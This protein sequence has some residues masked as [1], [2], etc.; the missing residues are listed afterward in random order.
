MA[1]LV[2]CVYDQPSST[3]SFT[4]IHNYLPSQVGLP[5]QVP[6]LAQFREPVELE[7]VYPSRQMRLYAVPWGLAD[8]GVE[9]TPEFAIETSVQVFTGK[10]MKRAYCRTGNFCNI[11]MS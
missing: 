8:V 5:V 2:L 3:T 11:K 7:A 6:S 1:P 10:R 4:M 9:L